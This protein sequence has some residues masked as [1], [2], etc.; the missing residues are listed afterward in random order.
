LAIG[1]FVHHAFN[2]KRGYEARSGLLEG[3]SMLESQIERLEAARARPERDVHLP[4]D[5]IALLAAGLLI[6]TPV[7]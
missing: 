6:C 3:S 5:R 7:R 4:H 1:C 2:G